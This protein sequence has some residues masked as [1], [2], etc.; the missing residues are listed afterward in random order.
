MRLLSFLKLLNDKLLRTGY[1][2]LSMIFLFSS[3][4]APMIIKIFLILNAAS[5]KW[6]F[7][8]HTYFSSLGLE[9][10]LPF[11]FFFER[12]FTN[13]LIKRGKIVMVGIFSRLVY[14]LLGTISPQFS[15]QLNYFWIFFSAE[16][17]NDF[18]GNDVTLWWQNIR[19]FRDDLKLT[20]H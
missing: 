8:L 2:Q 18:W 12:N 3:L 5:A 6:M 20:G 14:L 16:K 13:L 11:F 17:K 7:R 1:L 9:N 19:W 15:T 10:I 4:Q